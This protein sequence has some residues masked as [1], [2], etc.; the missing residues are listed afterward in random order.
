MYLNFLQK[1]VPANISY[2]HFMRE[3]DFYI[4][5]VALRY[6]IKAG[7]VNKCYLRGTHI[8]AD[9]RTEIKTILL[10]LLSHWLYDMVKYYCSAIFIPSPT[11]PHLID[12]LAVVLCGL[13]HQDK[14]N[15]F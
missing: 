3:K 15:I 7:N 12:I 2:F 9:I 8:F 4:H 6:V 1:V 11:L 10:E 13:V 14:A 5:L